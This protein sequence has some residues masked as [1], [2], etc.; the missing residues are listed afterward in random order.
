MLFLII[1]AGLFGTSCNPEKSRSGL[2]S[3]LKGN[4][5]VSGAFALYPMT[6]KWAEDLFNHP[7]HLPVRN[8]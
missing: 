7:V 4:I 3:G 6:V 1:I 8:Y 2:D 5:S